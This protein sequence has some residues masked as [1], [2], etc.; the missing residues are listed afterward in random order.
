MCLL[1]KARVFVLQRLSVQRLYLMA[2][3]HRYVRE[4]IISF[5]MVASTN[6]ILAT[7]RPQDV[8]A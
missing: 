8:Q 3:Y 4:N 6:V 1:A 2:T 7:K 5:A